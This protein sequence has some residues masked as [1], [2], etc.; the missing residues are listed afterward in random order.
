[1]TVATRK[2]AAK[3]ADDLARRICHSRGRCE[4]VSFSGV[5]CDST[6]VVWAHIIRRGKS[7]VLRCIED[8]CWAMCPTHHDLVDN[9]SDEHWHMVRRTIGEDRYYEMRR[10][11]VDFTANRKIPAPVFWAAEVERLKA[12]CV[13]LGLSTKAGSVNA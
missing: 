12:R 11:A 2:G 13:E 4:Y 6:E 9:Y 10:E 1:V 5:R 8:N 7:A 3:H